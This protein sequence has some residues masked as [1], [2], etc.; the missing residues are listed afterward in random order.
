MEAQVE[1]TDGVCGRS[2][3]LLINLIVAQ[4]THVVG[5]EDS[6]PHTEYI[7]PVGAVSAT[8]ADTIQLTC[9]KAELEQMDPFVRTGF[10]QVKLH[11]VA[12]PSSGR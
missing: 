10:V 8:I 3:H 1:C 7:V 9:S 2:A 12:I 4:V 6:S 11:D 5:R